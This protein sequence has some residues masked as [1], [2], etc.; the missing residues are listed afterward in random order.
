MWQCERSFISDE[1]L[2]SKVDEK[3]SICAMWIICLE[4]SELLGTGPLLD[5]MFQMDY[6]IFIFAHFNSWVRSFT[7]VKYCI[8]L[9]RLRIKIFSAESNDRMKKRLI[10]KANNFVL[11]DLKQ[12]KYILLL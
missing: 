11:N 5:R 6:V 7:I 3:E 12:C 1:L 4:H 9:I 2:K 10:Q 8:I